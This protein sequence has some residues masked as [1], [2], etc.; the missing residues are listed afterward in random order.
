M[1]QLALPP[2]ELWVDAK[3]GYRL[4]NV[5][6]WKSGDPIYV[7]P[8]SQY[9][10]HICNHT[11]LTGFYLSADSRT[12]F[13]G[14]MNNVNPGGDTAVLS[15]LLPFNT[16]GLGAGNT[17]YLRSPDVKDPML[18]IHVND[19]FETQTTTTTWDVNRLIVWMGSLLA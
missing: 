4:E 6:D 18:A 2:I 12:A 7:L 1:N 3:T 14:F 16:L 19:T 9:A 5:K 8:D 15:G 10:F 11:H 17:I 13:S